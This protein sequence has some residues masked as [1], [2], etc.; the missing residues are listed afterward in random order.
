MTWQKAIEGY[1]HT[2]R[3]Y[4]IVPP[5][6]FDEALRLYDAAKHAH[7]LFDVGLVDIAKVMAEEPVR[8]PGSLAEE[9]ITDNPYAQA[10]ADYL[11]GRVMKCDSVDELR[12]HRTGITRDGML[13]L[14]I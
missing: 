4:L 10:Y 6:R 9:I 3:F 12:K 8:L 5:E 1:L 11:L 13:Y 7:K 2:Q 14:I